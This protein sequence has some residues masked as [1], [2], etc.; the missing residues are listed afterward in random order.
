MATG[1]VQIRQRF[2]SPD[3]ANILTNH[4]YQHRCHRERQIVNIATQLLIGRVK[5]DDFTDTGAGEDGAAGE[6]PK[7]QMDDSIGIGNRDRVAANTDQLTRR[8]NAADDGVLAHG[9]LLI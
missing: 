3:T 8:D 5:Y 4:R 6:T 9:S 7:L 1:W 2:V